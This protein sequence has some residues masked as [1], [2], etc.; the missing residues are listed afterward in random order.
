MNNIAPVYVYDDGGVTRQKLNLEGYEQKFCF[1]VAEGDDQLLS[2]LNE[3]LSI[4]SVNGT[5]DELYQKWFPFLLENKGVSTAEMIRYVSYVLVPALV[6]LIAAYFVATKRTIKLRT[7]EIMI[8]KE[9]SEKYL[10]DLILSGKIFET[11]IL[12]API[13]I[14]I[15]AEDGTVIN[16]SKTWTSFTGYGSVP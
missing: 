10:N 12:N 14:M 9:R 8:E 13:P 16:I 3:G 1:A 11:S 2:I 7:N 6:F 5:Y 4:V 15:H